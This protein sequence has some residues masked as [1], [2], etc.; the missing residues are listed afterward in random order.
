MLEP[1]VWRAER[2]RIEAAYGRRR[3]IESRY[4]FSAPDT[5]VQEFFK[6]R[7]IARFLARALGEDLSDV[8]VLDV[9]CGRGDFLRVLIDWGAS[10]DRLV[11]VDLLADRLAMARARTVSGPQWICGTASDVPKRETFDLV[12][13][14]TVF[15]SIL[16]AKLRKALADEM[17]RRLDCGGWLL[18]FDFRVNSPRNS[19]VRAVVKREL[20]S[21]WSAAE[22]RSYRS[23]CLAPPLTRALAPISASLPVLLEGLFPFLRSHFLFV[24]R[25]GEDN[26]RGSEPLPALKPDATS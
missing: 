6:H 16:D 19:D 22:S 8:R 25:K 9:G 15:S 21:W 13:A 14:M 7:D 5:H 3:R 24:G 12:V 23:L 10:P 26:E 20:R 11:G 18:V 17:W 2:R 4:A 1:D